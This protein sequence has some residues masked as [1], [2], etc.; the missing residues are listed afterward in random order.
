MM[1]SRQSGWH[2]P[3]SDEEMLHADLDAD[4]EQETK[5]FKDQLLRCS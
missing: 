5:G 3:N 2:L 1:N 4:G